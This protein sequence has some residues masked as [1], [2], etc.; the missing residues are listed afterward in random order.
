M[1]D[2]YSPEATDHIVNLYLICDKVP[3]FFNDNLSS[4]QSIRY[5]SERSVYTYHPIS[6]H[7][8]SSCLAI[9]AEMHSKLKET[10]SETLIGIAPR[11]ERIERSVH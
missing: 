8:I 5:S 3:V 9:S 11:S 10:T 7:A 2:P 4:I 6:N 1:L